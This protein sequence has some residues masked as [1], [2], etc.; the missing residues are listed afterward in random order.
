MER[1]IVP[2]TTPEQEAFLNRLMDGAFGAPIIFDSAPT[3]SQLNPNT[4]GKHS[5]D[6]YVKFSDGVTLKLTGTVVS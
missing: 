6:V 4:W 5:T 2:K 1:I 3:A